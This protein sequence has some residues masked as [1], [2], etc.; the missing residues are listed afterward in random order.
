[1]TKPIDTSKFRKALL[2][3]LPAIR[4]A[5]NM[6]KYG[7][8]AARMIKV[9]TRL[10]FGVESDGAER[11]RLASLADVTIEERKR[12]RK[13]GSLHGDTSPGRSNLTRSGQLLDSIQTVKAK[14]GTATVAP[15]GDREGESLTNEE[16]AAY[17]HAGH[18][19]RPPRPFNYLSAS[20]RRRIV[21]MIR[22]DLKAAIRRFF[23]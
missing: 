15:R 14:I 10:G 21:E 12:L 11:E 13:K 22:K 3:V 4:S 6:K 17:T 7:D 8:E 2:A 5:E 19:A 18:G 16:L 20:E 23:K 9:R 1:M